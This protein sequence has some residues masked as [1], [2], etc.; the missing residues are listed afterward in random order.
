MTIK[1]VSFP[2]ALEALSVNPRMSC[3]AA[4]RH[5]NV[6]TAKRGHLVHSTEPGVGGGWDLIRGE[7]IKRIVPRPAVTLF[8]INTPASNLIDVFS[9]FFYYRIS[10]SLDLF[11]FDLEKLCF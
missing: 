7:Y 4:V 2:V 11:R 3:A 10:L 1:S 8:D 5:R 6:T 9:F